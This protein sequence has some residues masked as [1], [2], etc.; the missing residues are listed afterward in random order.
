MIP[1]S[2]YKDTKEQDAK[3]TYFG[4]Q[5]NLYSMVGTMPKKNGSEEN[6]TPLIEIPAPSIHSIYAVLYS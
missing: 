5:I 2:I 4:M 6:A 1:T 3:H